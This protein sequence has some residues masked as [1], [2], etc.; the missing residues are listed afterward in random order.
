MKTSPPD[1]SA[2]VLANISH[3][4]VAPLIYPDL[5]YDPLRDFTP[6]SKIVEFQIVNDQR[7]ADLVGRL[8]ADTFEHRTADLHSP[9]SVIDAMA[10]L[11]SS[12]I[13]HEVPVALST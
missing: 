11:S 7:P 3:M 9:F 4:G 10:V 2:I 13:G 12:G 5:P 6:I 8:G 1:G